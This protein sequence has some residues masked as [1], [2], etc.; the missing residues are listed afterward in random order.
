MHHAC[1]HLFA[2]AAAGRS[3]PV[4]T[5]PAPSLSRCNRPDRRSTASEA[6]LSWFKRQSNWADFQYTGQVAGYG[7]DASGTQRIFNAITAENWNAGLIEYRQTVL[8]PAECQ[9][10]CGDA[11][12][13]AFFFNYYYSWAGTTSNACACFRASVN[14][15]WPFA[16]VAIAPAGSNVVAGSVCSA[17]ASCGASSTWTSSQVSAWIR[18]DQHMD[19]TCSHSRTHFRHTAPRRES[20]G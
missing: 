5:P 15:D 19:S 11:H 20:A 10:Y 2:H 3:R 12:P 9:Y 14:I 4:T 13:E 1:T 16:P 7:V 18:Q 17:V 6:T 8:S